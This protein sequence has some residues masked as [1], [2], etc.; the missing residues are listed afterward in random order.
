[1]P[2]DGNVSWPSWEGIRAA[3]GGEG[4]QFANP[5]TAPFVGGV[6]RFAPIQLG[7]RVSLRR[8]FI[9]RATAPSMRHLVRA[10]PL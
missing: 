3:G 2:R 4:H 1:M 10:G 7:R 8:R 9:P 5:S 6:D